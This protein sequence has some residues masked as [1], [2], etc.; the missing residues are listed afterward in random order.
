MHVKFAQ[1]SSQMFAL[2]SLRLSYPI[3]I[4]SVH[5]KLRPCS[6][7]QTTASTLMHQWLCSEFKRYTVNRINNLWGVFPIIPSPPSSSQIYGYMSPGIHIP[8]HSCL[9]AKCSQ[10]QI[11]PPY[12]SG[13]V[14]NPRQRQPHRH[15]YTIIRSAAWFTRMSTGLPFILSISRI[16]VVTSGNTPIDRE[17]LLINLVEAGINL[18]RA[19]LHRGFK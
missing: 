6:A 12:R 2:P 14:R 13:F 1:S 19:G 18:G 7:H 17:V 8:R 5:C 16:W 15:A 9:P 11:A 10:I 3:F 4:G